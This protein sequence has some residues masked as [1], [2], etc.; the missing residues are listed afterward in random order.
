MFQKGYAEKSP[1][2]SDG[3]K[4]YISHHGVYH[5]AKPEKIRVAFDCGLEYLGYALNKQL[6]PGPD[7]TNQIVGV[8]IRFREEK[9]AFMGDIEAMFYQVRI[10]KYQQSIL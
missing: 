1:N 7:L 3:N 8:L 6:I 4:W 5:P 10:P 9:V 2:A